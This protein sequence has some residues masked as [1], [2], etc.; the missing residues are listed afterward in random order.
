[1]ASVRAISF[2]ATTTTAR[3]AEASAPPP[4]RHPHDVLITDPPHLP[5]TKPRGATATTTEPPN[6]SFFETRTHPSSI[7]LLS[8]LATRLLFSESARRRAQ[9]RRLIARRDDAQGRAR[10]P[11]GARAWGQR[12]VKRGVKGQGAAAAWRDGTRELSQ[13][14]LAAALAR[15]LKI[16]FQVRDRQRRQV[17]RRSWLVVWSARAFASVPRERAWSIGRRASSPRERVRSIGRRASRA[18]DQ[19]AR[20][21]GGTGSSPT[22]AGLRA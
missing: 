2:T 13:D 8:P 21:S 3:C 6:A 5:P 22:L 18:R 19:I 17:G 15:P 1:M 20:A 7:E 16:L 4:A 11:F 9:A 10:R 12:V 14:A